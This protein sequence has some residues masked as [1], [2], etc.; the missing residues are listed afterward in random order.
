MMKKREAEVGSWK[1][2]EGPGPN[3]PLESH[4][5]QTLLQHFPKDQ[6]RKNAG[7]SRRGRIYREH[8]LERVH[9]C[10][11]I[12]RV[13]FRLGLKKNPEKKKEKKTQTLCTER[14]HVRRY[15]KGVL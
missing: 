6:E 1:P 12:L 8:V 4:Y 10:A 5:G 9:M 13:Y 2:A 3:R 14:R 15:C 7:R 11:H